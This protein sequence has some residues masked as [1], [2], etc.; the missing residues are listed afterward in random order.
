MQHAAVLDIGVPADGD[1][2]IVAAQD[3]TEPDAGARFENHVSYQ[4]CVRRQPVFALR[5]KLWFLVAE[6]V[7]I[8]QNTAI[9]QKIEGF[10]LS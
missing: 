4:R 9:S 10:K 8:H 5:R 3:C 1:G 2:V 6:T 7:N